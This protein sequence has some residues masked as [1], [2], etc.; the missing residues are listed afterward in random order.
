MKKSS[1]YKVQYDLRPAKQAERRI[2]LEILKLGA[3]SGLDPSNYKYLGFGG[4]KFYDFEM[5]FRHLGIQDMTSLEIDESLFPRCHFNKPFGFI[6]THQVSLGEYLGTST[7]RKP[8]VAW[9]DYDCPLTRDVV[10]DLQ[11]IGSKA[12]VGSFVFATIDAR[13]PSDWQKYTPAQ[14][15]GILS[16]E[17]GGFALNPSSSNVQPNN[18]PKYAEK[19]LWAA[20]KAGL[21]KRSDGIFLPLVRIFYSDTTLMITAGGLLCPSN[22]EAAFKKAFKSEFPFL[23]GNRPFNIPSFNFTPRERHMLDVVVTSNRTEATL[24]NQLGRIGFT[25]EILEQ[26]KKLARFVPRYFEAYL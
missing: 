2:L 14:R 8:L 9:L 15:V 13:L 25:D 4:F 7:F 10:D 20:L 23:G 12:P 3:K 5:L 6:E 21:S 24:R 1:A 16:D 26:Y 18:F 17:L 11:T 22:I 19:V